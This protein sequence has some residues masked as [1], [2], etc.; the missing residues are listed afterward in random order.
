MHKEVRLSTLNVR[1]LTSKE[2]V[3]FLKDF[4]DYNKIDICFL[5]ETHISKVGDLEYLNECLNNYDIR[6]MLTDSKSRGVG[7]LVKKIEHFKV[8]FIEYDLE[9]RVFCVNANICN[10][11]LNLINIYAPNLSFFLILQ[12]KY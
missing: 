11:S 3:L 7:I 9:N 1:G 2:K 10:M 5:Q 12:A 4:L 6:T 8:N